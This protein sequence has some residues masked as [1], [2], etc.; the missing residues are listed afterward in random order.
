MYMALLAIILS[1]VTNTQHLMRHGSSSFSFLFA[2]PLTFCQEPEKICAVTV[3][4]G[5]QSL[6]SGLAIGE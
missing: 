3:A 2:A 1:W 5:R 6:T 4:E